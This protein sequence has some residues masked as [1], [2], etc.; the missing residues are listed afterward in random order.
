MARLQNHEP[1]FHTA[2]RGWTPMDS[3]PDCDFDACE[4]C[5]RVFH[6]DELSAF[7]EG[8]HICNE[9]R[10]FAAGEGE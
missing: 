6:T 7:C 10:E 5:L 9:C 8:E 4:W 2:H 1:M 3:E